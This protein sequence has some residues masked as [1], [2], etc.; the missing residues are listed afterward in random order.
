M[1]AYPWPKDRITVGPQP[2]VSK[3]FPGSS[4]G[5][6]S[7]C[8]SGDPGLIPGLGRSPGKGIGFP[9][10]CS[11]A[12]L[13]AQ[14]VKNLPAMWETWVWSLGW[15]DRLEEVMATHSSILAWRIPMDRGDWWSTVHR[16]AK[17]LTRLSDLHTFTFRWHWWLH[18][19]YSCLRQSLN[20]V[21]LFPL[22]SVLSNQIRWPGIH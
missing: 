15:E 19:G 3:G 18:A 9:L 11:W 21:A 20:E 6:E 4:A 14:T 8:N 17:N 7:T 10:Q 22:R 12:S 1:L 2:L 5:R 13:V 16:V